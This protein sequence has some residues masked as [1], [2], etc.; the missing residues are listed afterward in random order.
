M[1]DSR[2]TQSRSAVRRGAVAAAAVGLLVGSVGTFVATDQRNPAPT[3]AQAELEPLPGQQ[4]RGVAQVRE[5]PNGPVLMVDVAD[6]PATD[7][8]FE[9]W[10]LTPEADSMVSVG[11]LGDGAVSEFPLPSGMDMEVFPVVDIS[12]EQFDGD[13]THS[14]DSVVRGALAT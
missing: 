10:M 13:V 6:L 3:I 14:A 5:T 2:T 7:G 8:Y 9:V 1:N 11:V 4:A 12:V